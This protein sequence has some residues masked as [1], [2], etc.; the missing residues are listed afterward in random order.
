MGMFLLENRWKRIIARGFLRRLSGPGERNHHHQEFE[1]NI[2]RNI[3]FTCSSVK[4][5][6]KDNK[7]KKWKIM[8]GNE[9]YN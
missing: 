7:K 4:T 2:E 6:H 9:W 8:I 1:K 3:S 5:I